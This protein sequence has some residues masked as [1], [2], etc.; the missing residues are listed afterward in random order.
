M[1]DRRPNVSLRA[2][3]EEKEA[4]KQAAKDAGYRAYTAWLRAIAN[5]AAKDAGFEPKQT[6]AEWGENFRKES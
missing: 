2:T 5:E 6:T 4:W 1:S 3:D